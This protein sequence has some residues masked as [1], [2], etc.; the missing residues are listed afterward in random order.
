MAP[1]A[2]DTESPN[3]TTNGASQLKLGDF[4]IDE[5]R[6]MRVVV[7][8]AGYSGIMAGIRFRQKMN[9]INL[10]IYEKNAGI[11]GTWYSNKYPGVACDVPSHCYQ[12]SFTKKTDWSSFY[13]PGPE[14]RQYI[15]D[16]AKEYKLTPYIKLRHELTHARWDDTSGKWILRI[17]KTTS[18]TDGE[19]TEE[20]EDTADFM[21]TAAGILSRWKWPEIEGLKSFQ[22]QLIHSANF[23][24]GEQTW[25]EAAK[26]WGEKRVAVIGIGSSA[27][28]IIPALEDKVAKITNY[29]RG[30][31]WLAPP[32]LGS[33]IAEC[34][35]RDPASENLIF[36]EEEKERFSEPEFFKRY[37]HDLEAEFQALNPLQLR[38]SELQK[39]YRALFEKNM[40]EKLAN[41][42]EIAEKLVPEFGVSCR[43]LT[44]GPGYLEALCKDHV[45]F[46][47]TQIK[48]IT[49]SGIETVDGKH[50]EFDIIICA[51]GYDT[52]CKFEYPMIGRGGVKLQD[53]W[54]PHPE[55]YLALAVDGFPNWTF[56]L[57]PNGAIAVGLLLHI[58]EHQVL[59][60]VK[61]AQKLQ[62][63]RYK[64]IEPKPE[65]VKAFDQ[66]LEAYF[67]KTVFAD[68][69]RSW[70]KNGN[71][72]GRNTGLWPGSSVHAL[73]AIAHP[74]WED[75]K[76]EL[77][78]PVDNCFY[79]LGDGHTHGEKNMTGDLAWYLSDKEL[80]VPPS[81]RPSFLR[82]KQASTHYRSSSIRLRCKCNRT[83]L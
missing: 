8:G 28:Q 69:C 23:D 12:M 78:D 68:K 62:R 24:V 21:F 41:R 64:S 61:I 56:S 40:K 48:R 13:A 14:I 19:Q 30:Q 47:S 55:T 70:Y 63:E 76:Y 66:Y 50:E 29:G 43:R 7:I 42:P 75:F 27:L 71:A 57:G 73:R 46:V 72:E 60:A 32:F 15:E 59:Y 5:D 51:T 25:Q 37:R 49:S 45:S 3:G 82:M 34:I 33:R 11:G 26:G 39:Q 67:P 74:R 4:S 18:G 52:S 38:N 22:G 6:P 65:V 83:G 1:V 35:G 20:F 58:M 10:T 80:D 16:T 9:N 79:W 53:R 81:K 77:L 54:S 31:T 17:R 44:P 2:Y 36:T